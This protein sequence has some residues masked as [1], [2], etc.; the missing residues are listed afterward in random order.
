MASK[1]R[2]PKTLELLRLMEE[3]DLT[4]R[5]VAQMVGRTRQCVKRWTAEFTIIEQPMLDLLKYRLA[6]TERV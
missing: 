2:N 3:H 4:T 1:R 6:D 5:A